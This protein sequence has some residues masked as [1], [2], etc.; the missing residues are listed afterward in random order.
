MKELAYVKE[1]KFL[2]SMSILVSSKN[3]HFHIS[4][5]YIT[6]VISH[7]YSAYNMTISSS[8]R[9]CVCVCACVYTCSLC[10]LHCSVNYLEYDSIV[11]L[12]LL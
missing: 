5:L 9:N 12:L 10:I 4:K 7:I 11:L 2:M 6:Y 1:Y 8:K 3:V